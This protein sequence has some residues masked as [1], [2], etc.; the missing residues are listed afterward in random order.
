MAAATLSYRP[1]LR[2]NFDLLSRVSETKRVGVFWWQS[3]L[4]HACRPEVRVQ[5]DD[6]EGLDGI[7]DA[8]RPQRPEATPQDTICISFVLYS[9]KS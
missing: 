1:K 3:L 2:P 4:P 7:N 9:Q 8:Q 5:H 6:P